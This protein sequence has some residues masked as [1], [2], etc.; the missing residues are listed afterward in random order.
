MPAVSGLGDYILGGISTLSDIN[1]VVQS[2][3]DDNDEGAI[4][5]AGVSTA[6]KTYTASGLQLTFGFEII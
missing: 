3:G 1:L 5:V 6:T 4:Y 2:D